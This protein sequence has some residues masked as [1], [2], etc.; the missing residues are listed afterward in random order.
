MEKARQFLKN[1]SYD[2]L[3]VFNKN[4]ELLY[5][6]QYN[7]KLFD[8]ECGFEELQKHTDRK[9]WKKFKMFGKH[10]HIVGMN[11]VLYFFRSWFVSVGTEV[12][13][14]GELWGMRLPPMLERMFS[15]RV[16]HVN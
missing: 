10:V 4:M 1:A 16:N 12:S 13:V 9:L 2:I 6:A 3:P 7:Q 5:F 11:N 14:E 15:S 8:R